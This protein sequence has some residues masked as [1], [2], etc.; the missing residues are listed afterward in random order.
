VASPCLFQSSSRSKKSCIWAFGSF[1]GADDGNAGVSR[2]T[3]F[4]VVPSKFDLC[5]V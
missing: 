2:T 3:L 1:G 4:A 5:R